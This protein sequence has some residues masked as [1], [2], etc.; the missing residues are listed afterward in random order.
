MAKPTRALVAIAFA[1]AILAMPLTTQADGHGPVDLPPAPPREKPAHPR[2][3][4]QL[5]RLA[6]QAA[7]AGQGG[8]DVIATSA[9]MYSGSSVAVTVRLSNGA[10]AIAAF[11]EEGGGIAANIGEDY[12]EAY[13]P[14]PLLA[15]L[16]ELENVV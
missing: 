11:I 16:S 8:G 15:E 4:S 2:L 3:D 14:P 9:L 6:V 13:V 1:I 10:D 12:V 5:N 7:Q